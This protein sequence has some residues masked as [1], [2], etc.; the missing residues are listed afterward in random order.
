MRIIHIQGTGTINGRSYERYTHNIFSKTLSVNRM[1]M[2]IVIGSLCAL[3]LT[4][5][6]VFMKGKKL[7]CFT[8]KSKP[9]GKC[10]YLDHNRNEVT[11]KHNNTRRL[12]MN[13][14]DLTTG[15]VQSIPTA[16]PIEDK[17]V[18]LSVN[19]HFT[20]KCNYSCGFCFHTAKT[21]FVLPL[22]EAKRG[23]EMLKDAGMVLLTNL[24]LYRA[25]TLIIRPNNHN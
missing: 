18:P 16:L 3:C 1:E 7:Q 25:C 13:N 21:S 5:L 10:E 24:D 12:L 23:L 15:K 14:N 22:D 4:M 8:A 6:H 11:V 20:R 2:V 19:Y 9:L 17:I